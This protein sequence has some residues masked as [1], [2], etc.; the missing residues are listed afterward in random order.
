MT[1]E[2]LISIGFKNV[3]KLTTNRPKEMSKKK[4][5]YIFHRQRTTV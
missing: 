3:G 2:E 4:A 1:I 5:W